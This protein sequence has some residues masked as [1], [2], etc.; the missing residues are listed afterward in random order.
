MKDFSKIGMAT[1]DKAGWQRT[2]AAML[3]SV[4]YFAI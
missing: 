1:R 2:L 3:N 4:L